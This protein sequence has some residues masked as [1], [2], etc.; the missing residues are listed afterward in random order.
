MMIGGEALMQRL[1]VFQC[2]GH[3][4]D[5]AQL[6]RHRR[7]MLAKPGCNVRRIADFHKHAIGDRE[8]DAAKHTAIGT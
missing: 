2:A 7:L 1:F 4:E 6:M 3:G 5:Q 8:I